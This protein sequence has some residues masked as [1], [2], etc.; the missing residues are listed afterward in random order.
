MLNVAPFSCTREYLSPDAPVD[1]GYRDGGAQR[2]L[3]AAVPRVQIPVE[4]ALRLFN[5]DQIFLCL[6]TVITF[7]GLVAAV[8]CI[9][10]RKADPLLL[11]FAL[12]SILYGVR[13]VVRHQPTW[14]LHSQSRLVL[15]LTIGLGYLVPIPAYLFFKELN[16]FHRIGRILLYAVAPILIVLSLLTLVT[17]P[18]Y[19]IANIYTL[20]VSISLIVAAV[21]LALDRS[22]S[23]ET[24]LIQQGLILFI[25]GALYENLADFVHTIPYFN[26]EPFAFLVLLV[27]LG[28]VAAR[29]TL[30]REQ[31]LRTIENEL[32]I[33]Q[34]I[35]RSILPTASPV[36][37]F[38]E[39]ATQY[40]PMTAVAGDFYE[41]ISLRN[42]E[43][44]L[45]IADVSGHGVPAAL[46]ASMVK[47]VAASLR[48]VADDPAE[49]LR[50]MNGSLC[51]NVQGQFVT[52]AYVYLNSESGELRYS[53]AAHPP[54]L[55]LRENTI[56]PIEENGLLLGAF[57]FAD[58]TTKTLPLRH[59]DRIL[60]YTD[61][62]LEAESTAGEEFGVER[63]ASLLRDN[64]DLSAEE[65][66]RSM[67]KTV[68]QWSAAQSDD[69]TVMVCDYR[70]EFAGATA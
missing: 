12:F 1:N 11:W 70:N 27:V 60:L 17:G 46:I 3:I 21:E 31:Q 30:A 14:Q 39:V 32:D 52:A 50:R 65:C 63:L 56:L 51:G 43:V 68:M 28:T 69:L 23:R 5:Y 9:L 34:R 66:A 36:S 49:V 26:V 6:G 57:D 19:Q 25:V 18:H 7:A 16:L 53:A 22:V 67:M 45:F 58:Y 59:G 10:R 40:Q 29:R 62:M 61:G 48:A 24:R 64:R 8:V 38:F 54:M 2:M 37:D 4:E 15:W 35:Q 42:E 33:A 47:A 41:Y 55:W 13:L 44:A 20:V